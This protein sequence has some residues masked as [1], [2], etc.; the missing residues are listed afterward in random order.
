MT[1]KKHQKSNPHIGTGVWVGLCQNSKSGSPHSGMGFI[2]I[3]GPT[4]TDELGNGFQDYIKLKLENVVYD[5]MC[6]YV[7]RI[8]LDIKW[9]ELLTKCLGCPFIC[10]ITPSNIA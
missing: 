9:K 8:K 4:Y 3:W 2:P 5:F 10:C 6:T 7:R 1:E